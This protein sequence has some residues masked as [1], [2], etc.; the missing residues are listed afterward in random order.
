M[1]RLAPLAWPLLTFLALIGIGLLIPALAQVLDLALPFFGLILLGFCLGRI[2]DV[3]EDG[4]AWMHLFVVYVALPALFFNLIAVTPLDQLANWG[5][6]GI[7][8]LSTTIAFAIAFGT[9]MVASR[10]NVAEATIQGVGGA[11]SNVGYMGPGLTLAALGPQSAVPTALVFVCDSMLLFTLVPFLMGIAGAQKMSLAQTSWLVFKRIV[12]HPFNIATV[13]GIVAAYMHWQPPVAIGKMLGFLQ[14]AA[15]PCALFAMGVTVAMRPLKRIAPE[16]PVLLA[17]KLVLHPLLVW[18]LLSLTGDYGRIWTFTAVLMAALPPALNVFVMAN[19]YRTYVEPAS[20]LILLGTIG[21]VVT[22][23]TILF[24]I[25][26]GG[27][28]YRLFTP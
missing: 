13:L 26:V 1:S 17:I 19:Q 15:A 27:V 16:M 12:T 9:G 20:G 4:L 28:P 18:T 10:G 5:F 24:L 23:T 6:I 21:S 22:L 11:Y 7:T 2:F 14:N 25:A 3:P 8:T